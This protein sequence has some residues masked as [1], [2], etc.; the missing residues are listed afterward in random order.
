MVPSMPSFELHGEKA[1]KGRAEF[2]FQAGRLKAP[3]QG[4]V[5]SFI[6]LL[7]HSFIHS[8]NQQILTE[9]LL[10][11]HQYPGPRTE[12][13]KT[14]CL[15]LRTASLGGGKAENEIKSPEQ[16]RRWQNG[17]ARQMGLEAP[18]WLKTAL[19]GGLGRD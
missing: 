14:N 15:L 1:T 8:A 4:L 17:E 6:C 10:H 2:G 5:C 13:Q 19:A 18:L 9:G 16:V 3:S 12:R 11:A 7:Q